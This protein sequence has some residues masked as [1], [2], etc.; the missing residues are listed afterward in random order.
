M[1]TLYLCRH[2]KSDWPAGVRDLD[3]P[4]K[5]RGIND[6]QFLGQLLASQDFSVDRI[7]SSPANRAKSTAKI[8]A[9]TAGHTSSIQIEECVYHEGVA[10]LISFVRQLPND[11]TSAMIFGHN[12]TMEDT[13][14][15]LLN[16]EADFMLPTSAIACFESEGHNWT[17]FRTS[18]LQLRWLL[19]PRLQRK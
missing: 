3:R 11:L 1:K 7:I 17:T 19:V 9:Q 8:I 15:A 4:L 10:S 12:P 2:A 5:E 13:V 16:S 18:N 6:A 14:Q